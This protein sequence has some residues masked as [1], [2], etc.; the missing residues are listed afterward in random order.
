M[1]ADSVTRSRRDF[2]Q[3][4]PLQEIGLDPVSMSTKMVDGNSV[5]NM[6]MCY[7]TRLMWAYPSKTDAGQSDV[8]RQLMRDY[9]TPHGHVIEV[10]HSDSGSVFLSKEFQGLCLKNGI[11]QDVSA[12]YLHQHNIVEGG[13]IRVMINHTQVVL[14]DSGLPPRFA[15]FAM[16]ESLRTWNQMV[17]PLTA[18]MSPIERVTGEKPDISG[19]RAFGAVCYYFTAS[20]RGICRP[21]RAGRIRRPRSF[22]WALLRE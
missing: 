17:H 1:R 9:V 11:K 13:C 7:G 6:G 2:S 15:G 4:K 18:E 5:L 8:L 22:C 16:Q 10:V 19:N 12:P 20:R 14:A 21:T 3:L